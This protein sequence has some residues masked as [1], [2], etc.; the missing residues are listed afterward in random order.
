MKRLI[1]L[2]LGLMAVGCGSYDYK[3]NNLKQSVVKFDDMPEAIKEFF[4]NPIGYEKN[5]TGIILLASLDGKGKFTLETVETWAGP[6][7]A[8]DKLIDNSRNKSY[9]IDQGVPYPY[10]I[11]ENKLYLTDRF[12]VFTTVKDYST[13]K[14]TCYKLKD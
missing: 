1:I 4:K 11:Y 8:Y 5:E 6:W 10:V 12:N 2:F 14:F 9:R 13:L 3:I 7:V